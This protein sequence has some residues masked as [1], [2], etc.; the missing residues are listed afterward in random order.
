VTIGSSTRRRCTSW[1]MC[2]A[3]PPRRD[4]LR[5][6]G[7]A[8]ALVTF[9]CVICSLRTQISR[10]MCNFTH[11]SARRRR[12]ARELSHQPLQML[13]LLFSLSPFP[14]FLSDT[15]VH[16][17]DV[18]Y[19]NCR[20]NSLHSGLLLT[21]RTRYTDGDGKHMPKSELPPKGWLWEGEW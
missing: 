1:C 9:I 7:I 4:R 16:A 11:Y 19:E 13:T 20:I 17:V 5:T 2:T 21:D 8:S 18:V 14:F 3:R 10:T 15:S 12:S 6:V